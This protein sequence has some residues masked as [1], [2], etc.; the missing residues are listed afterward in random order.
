M[1]IIVFVMT[2]LLLSGA[3]ATDATANS[4]TTAQK[5][6]APASPK[7]IKDIL[8]ARPF[9]LTK[10]Y[11]ND[12]SKEH[13]LVSSGL[14]VVLEVDPLLVAPRDAAEPVL[15]A[16]NTPVQRLNHGDRSGRV[17]GIVPF[18]STR[19]ARPELSRSIQLA[20]HPAVTAV[21]SCIDDWAK[22]RLPTRR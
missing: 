10:G 15:Y 6:A 13:A 20:P 9:T 8:Y 17:I 2:A 12:W 11:R 22:R 19:S 14:L 1:K 7:P 5:A 3:Q 16:G 18:A 4:N 21:G